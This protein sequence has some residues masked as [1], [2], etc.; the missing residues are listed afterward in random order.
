MQGSAAHH[1]FHRAPL[2]HL[3]VYLAQL[4]QRGAAAAQPPPPVQLPSGRQPVHPRSVRDTAA[5]AVLT[6]GLT[7]YEKAKQQRLQLA[8]VQQAEAVR[9]RQRPPGQRRRAP[10]LAELIRTEQKREGMELRIVALTRAAAVIRHQTAAEQRERSRII[11]E[12]QVC[13]TCFSS[14]GSNVRVV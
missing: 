3:C 7:P 6:T 12:L 2:H 10:E 9:L 11:N 4:M 8:Q 13:A 5:T 14:T 1:L